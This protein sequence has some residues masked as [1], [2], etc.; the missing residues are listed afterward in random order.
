MSLFSCSNTAIFTNSFPPR[1]ETLAPQGFKIRLDFFRDYMMVRTCSKLCEQAWCCKNLRKGSNASTRPLNKADFPSIFY[2][3]LKQPQDINNCF[4]IFA[5]LLKQLFSKTK[6]FKSDPE[7]GIKIAG[8]HANVEA[9]PL[10]LQMLQHPR[11]GGR[12]ESRLEQIQ[13][14]DCGRPH[15]EQISISSGRLWDCRL[16]NCRLWNCPAGTRRGSFMWIIIISLPGMV[17]GFRPR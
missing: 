5:D 16:W 6:S 10:W 12:M 7:K 11:V 3:F 15:G 9:N 2:Q 4:N 17:S 8:N 14:A 1:S 13:R